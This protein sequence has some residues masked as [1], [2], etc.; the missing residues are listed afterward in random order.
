MDITVQQRVGALLQQG[1]FHQA[2]IIAEKLCGQCTDAEP[3]LLLASVY[4]AGGDIGNVRDCCKKALEFDAKNFQA[5]FNYAISLENL[6]KIDPAISHYKKT[7]ALFPHNPDICIKLGYLYHRASKYNKACDCFKTVL[8]ANPKHIGAMIGLGNALLEMHQFDKAVDC[9]LKLTKVNPDLVEANFN[10]ATAYYRAGKSDLAIR[11]FQKVIDNDPGNSNAF[12]SLGAALIEEREFHKAITAYKKAI[13]FHADDVAA[14]TNLGNAYIEVGLVNDAI[15]CHEKA[16]EIDPEY[17]TALY[18]MGSLYAA[19]GELDKAEEVVNKALKL[20]PKSID[21]I[22]WKAVILEIRGDVDHAFELLNPLF[23]KGVVHA[24]FVLTYASL[25]VDR[26]RSENEEIILRLEK[27]LVENTLTLKERT[28]LCFAIGDKYNDLGNFDKA[29]KSY[30]KAN[31]NIFV[32][33]NMNNH[34]KLINDI[35]SSFSNMNSSLN[36]EIDKTTPSPIFI[37]GMPRSGTS[38]VEQILSTNRDVFG[39]GELPDM[40]DL[41]KAIPDKYQNSGQYPECIKSL[42]KNQLEEISSSYL[43]VINKLS[44]SEKHVTDKTPLNY[45]Y[46]GIIS[47]LFPDARI[48]HCTRDPVDTCLSCYFNYFIGSHPY[49]QDLTTLGKCYKDYRRLM[50]H[51]TSTLD[52]PILEV[53]YESLVIDQ[54]S[55]SK[56]IMEFCDLEW[57]DSCLEFY[58]SDRLSNTASYNQ[59]RKPIYTK[60]VRRRDKYAGHIDQLLLA[61]DIKN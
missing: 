21:A 41:I 19:M 24:N 53:S 25:E 59:V 14:Y 40:H 39:A 3:W 31:N 48:I 45:M 4:A 27:S 37:V 13:S 2:R 50:E 26:T 29:F 30:E 38:L 56:S 16:I 58:K 10:L 43:N 11:Y 61:L 60:S 52:I 23:K 57:N 32:P 28:S 17:I 7:L 12:N 42:E 20:S 35:I 51:W 6:G 22:V 47:I 15:A 33:V 46:L 44:E 5:N 55:V 18:N 34:Y 36:I 8:A 54:L 1:D 9:Y 49:F